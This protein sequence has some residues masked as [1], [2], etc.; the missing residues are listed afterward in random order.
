M[1]KPRVSTTRE[2]FGILGKIPERSAIQKKWNHHFKINS[3]DAFLDYY[4]ITV[5]TIPERL[6]EMY[7]FDRRAYIVGSALTEAVYRYMD[8]LDAAALEEGS[9]NLIINRDGKLHGYYVSDNTQ[10]ENVLSFIA[11]GE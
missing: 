3:M 10:I 8:E 2:I 11:T 4:P 5:E 9:V 1:T 7:H 6:S